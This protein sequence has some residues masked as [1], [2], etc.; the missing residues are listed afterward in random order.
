MGIKARPYRLRI[1]MLRHSLIYLLAR[2]IPALLNFASI[3][4]FTRMLAPE[5]YG[6]YALVISGL[7]LANVLIYQ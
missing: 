5:T 4:V 1:F 3:A 6:Q 2:G 7:T